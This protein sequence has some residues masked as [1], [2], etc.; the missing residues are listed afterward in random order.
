MGFRC[1]ETFEN[2]KRIGKVICKTTFLMLLAGF[3][4]K[5]YSYEYMFANSII[6]VR[7]AI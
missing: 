6:G 3:V 7:L 2:L 4:G 5:G 1:V